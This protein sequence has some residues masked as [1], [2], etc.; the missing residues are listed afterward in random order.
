MKELQIKTKTLFS[1]E[2]GVLERGSDRIL[3]ICKKLNADVYLSG[4]LGSDY[5]DLKNFEESRIEV[6]FQNFQHPEYEQYYKPFIPN[7]AGIDL[8]FNEGKNASK[9]LQESKNFEE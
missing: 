9:I 3:A 1:S 5:L 4:K 2:L 8:I 6:R 7:M